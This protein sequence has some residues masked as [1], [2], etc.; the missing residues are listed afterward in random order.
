MFFF[1]PGQIARECRGRHA[2]A[3]AVGLGG[4]HRPEHHVADLPP[5]VGDFPVV[6]H[7]V[8]GLAGLGK[9]LGGDGVEAAE[10]P[11][12]GRRGRALGI[13]L[14]AGEEGGH[15]F[16]VGVAVGQRGVE[17]LGVERVDEKDEPDVAL[18]TK[19]DHRGEGVELRIG[20]VGAPWIVRLRPHVLAPARVLREDVGGFEIGLEQALVAQALRIAHLLAASEHREQAV[21]DGAG[22]EKGGREIGW[23][24]VGLRAQV[25][26]HREPL[27]GKIR[28]GQR[29]GV[30][31]P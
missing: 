13:G 6:A 31:H 28:L 20:A 30:E 23:Q 25:R 11:H 24:P 1:E 10:I 3:E 12:F 17:D 18:R 22:G 8:Y 29:V 21:A 9:R 15:P 4:E 27:L 19:A 7:P 5:E 14:H 16:P 26:I 2:T